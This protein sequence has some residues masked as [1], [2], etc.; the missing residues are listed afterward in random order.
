[1]FR[2]NVNQRVSMSVDIIQSNLLLDTGFNSVG[3]MEESAMSRLQQPIAEISEKIYRQMVDLAIQAANAP[4]VED[5]HAIRERA[6][7]KYMNLSAAL[8][9][10][11]RAKLDLS[12]LPGLVDASFVALE[13]DFYSEAESYFGSD[14]RDEIAFS[15]STLRGAYRWISHLLTV[16]PPAESLVQDREYS[17]H[18]AISS[19]WVH[20]HLEGLKAGLYKGHVIVPAVVQE[21]LEG[22]RQ[23][24]MAYAYVRAALDLRGVLNDRY[25]EALSVTWDEEDEALARAD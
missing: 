10:V 4:S 16:K 22:L 7:P 9:N 12:D 17:N 2:Y 18:F 13:R 24:V 14:V 15:L 3:I 21:L 20:F 1:M 8:G 11:I 5:F 19:T 25:K 6:F 23:S